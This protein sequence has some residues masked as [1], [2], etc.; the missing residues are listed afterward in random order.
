M[1]QIKS[2]MNILQ[3]AGNPE[4]ALQ[5]ILAT[6]PQLR[7]YVQIINNNGGDYRKAFYDLA[8]QKGVNPEEILNLIKDAS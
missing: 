4:V 2:M 8:A 6:N 1:G 5:S 7:E 3:C